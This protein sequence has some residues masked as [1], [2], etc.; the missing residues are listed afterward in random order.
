MIAPPR[1]LLVGHDASATGAPLALLALVSWAHASGAAQIEVR[2]DRGG[3]LESALV[4]LAPTTVTSARTRSVATVLDVVAGRMW[5]Q[6]LRRA[7]ARRDH[8]VP[9]DG[10]VVVAA[11][12]ASWP[13]AAV[14]APPGRLVLWLHEL[15]G[16]VDR[17]LRP[18]ERRA[19]LSKTSHIVAV[20]ERVAAMVTERWGVD[21][22]Q[23]TVVDSFVDAPRT[24]ATAPAEGAGR[25]RCDVLAIG[26]LVPRK[27]AEHVVAV[28]ALLARDRPSL[29]SAWVGGDLATPYADLIRADLAAAELGGSFVLAG[30]VDELEPWWPRSGVVVHLPREDPAPLVVVEAALRSVPVVTWDTGGA[31][32]LVR[33]AGLDELVVAPGDVA[34]A[35]AQ[36]ARLLDDPTAR[37]AAGS[38]LALAA[39]DRTTDQQAPKLLDA[40]LTGLR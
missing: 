35:A 13:T 32:D 9:D 18:A 20:G 12:A 23:V 38:A 21:H 16:V 28:A 11:S 6:G 14:L 10:T 26:S 4:E 5:G 31:A 29:R 17:L 15:D 22:D 39:R 36:V 33:G 19:L 24:E 1:V 7:L 27:G 34:A 40:F 25:Q 37:R 30:A 8:A 2:L 3:P